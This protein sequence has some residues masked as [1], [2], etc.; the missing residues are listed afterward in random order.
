MSRPF[1]AIVGFAAALI[2]GLML[3]TWAALGRLERVALE[4]KAKSSTEK[5]AASVSAYTVIRRIETGLPATAL[6]VDTKDRLFIA[7]NKAVWLIADDGEPK[8]IVTLA[9]EPEALVVAEDGTCYVALRH[10]V[11]V[12]NATGMRTAT[13]QGFGEKAYITSLTVDGDTVW[14]ADAGHRTIHRLRTDGT[15][16]GQV[17]HGLV[18]PSPHLDVAAGANG[19]VLVANPGRHRVETYNTRGRLLTH[20]GT[21]GMGEKAFS[22]CCNPA[23]FAR[24]PDGRVV[25]AEKGLRRVK[26]YEPD[27]AFAALVAG[28]ETFGKGV[29]PVD[30]ACDGQ[31]RIYTLERETGVVQVFAPAAKQTP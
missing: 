20:W 26:V 18:V 14:V 11:Q 28:P 23:D 1:G 27:G 30:L 31:G 15:T 22:G 29:D 2:I 5:P 24:L 13:W 25:T 10:S 6:A 17:G 21:A 16:L 8:R 9:A 19:T 4:R 3:M 7:G 12:F